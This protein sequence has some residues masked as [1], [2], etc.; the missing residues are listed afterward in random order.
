MYEFDDSFSINMCMHLTPQNKKALQG[1]VVPSVCI[2]L[3]RFE[4][5]ITRQIFEWFQIS[6]QMKTICG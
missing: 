4:I 2:N 3:S 6:F 1:Y 5:M